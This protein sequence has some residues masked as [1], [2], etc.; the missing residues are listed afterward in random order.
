M[1]IGCVADM[2]PGE[3]ITQKAMKIKEWGFEGISLFIKIENLT[4]DLFEEINNLDKSTGIVPCEI[5]LMSSLYGNLMHDDETVR[6]EA[7][8]LYERSIEIAGLLGAVTE[9]EFEYKSQESLPLF[10]PYREM[11]STLRT[12]FVHLI[13]KLSK[14]A[15]NCGAT[16]LL[17][18]CNRYETRYITRLTD[19]ASILREISSKSTGILADFFHMSIEEADIPKSIIESGSFI[20]HVHLGDSNRLLPGTGHTDFLSAFRALTKIEF[21]GYMCLECGILGNPEVELP[22]CINFLRDCIAK[23][24]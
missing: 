21:Q 14:R 18:P 17:E 10:E 9:M 7:L 15:E 23:A 4:D 8:K 19:A 2:V 12:A 16:L 22:K 24:Q 6:L 3:S 13:E 20:K 5:V 1:K 11:P